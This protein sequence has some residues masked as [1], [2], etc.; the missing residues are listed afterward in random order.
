MKPISRRTFVRATAGLIA[1]VPAAQA[2]ARVPTAEACNVPINCE[3][4]CLHG[5]RYSGPDCATYCPGGTDPNCYAPVYAIYEESCCNYPEIICDRSQTIERWQ[6][7]P[8]A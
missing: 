8:H 1:F 6:R 4:Y 3:C 2:L 7:C 5:I